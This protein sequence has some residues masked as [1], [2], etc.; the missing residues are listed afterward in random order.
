MSFLKNVF[1]NFIKFILLFVNFCSTGPFYLFFVFAILIAFFSNKS[2]YYLVTFC[3]FFAV[4]LLVFSI[5]IFIILNLKVTFSFVLNLLGSSFLEKN[6]FPSENVLRAL[7]PALLYTSTLLFFLLLDNVSLAFF[8]YLHNVK[9]EEITQEM[10]T[11]YGEGKGIE[12]QR[13][14]DA[15]IKS[16]RENVYNQGI[17][18]KMVNNKM[19]QP[20]IDFFGKK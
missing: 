7:R 2:E 6:F 18:R 8:D 11:L 19:V 1:I 15:A 20:F 14:T 10:K 17:V 9:I 4:C 13:E 3:Q 5:L 12:A 16:I